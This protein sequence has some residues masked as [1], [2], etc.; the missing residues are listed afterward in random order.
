M[1]F[2]FARKRSYIKLHVKNY[3]VGMDSW[4]CHDGIFL[5]KLDIDELVFC[6]IYSDLLGNLL[7]KK[8]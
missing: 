4:H 7:P 6:S 2:N 8:K 5:S 3:I 1:G